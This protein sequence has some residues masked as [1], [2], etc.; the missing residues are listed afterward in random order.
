MIQVIC[1]LR[2]QNLFT[3]LV[4]HRLANIK[5]T[6][7]KHFNFTNNNHMV[8]KTKGQKYRQIKNFSLN[9]FILHQL[10]SINFANGS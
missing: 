5:Q 6:F 9:T 1:N 3:P 8:C 7:G 2:G 4:Y 10:E